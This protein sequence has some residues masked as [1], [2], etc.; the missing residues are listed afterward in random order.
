MEIFEIE[1]E[2]WY[3]INISFDWLIS[4]LIIMAL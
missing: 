1:L 4:L 3:K 2:E